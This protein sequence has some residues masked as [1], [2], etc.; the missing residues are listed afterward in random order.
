METP[1][2]VTARD[3]LTAREQLLYERLLR[4]YPDD[5]IFVQVALSQLIDVDQYHPDRE[6]IRARFKQLVADFVLCRGDLSIVAVVEL[7]DRSHERWDR[8]AADARKT[9]ALTDAG[10]R[11][12]R[13]PAGA[14]PSDERLKSIIDTDAAGDGRLGTFRIHAVAPE[15]ELG[16]A[17]DWGSAPIRTPRVIMIRLPRR[18]CERH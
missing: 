16:L 10:I 7:D 2:P 4:L 5:K 14:L 18:P 13:V 12:V 11:L 8:Q 15:P 9:K 6:S 3:L 17:E 1:W